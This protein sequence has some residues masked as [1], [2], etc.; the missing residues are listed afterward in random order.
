MAVGTERLSA[1][2][3][4]AAAAKGSGMLPLRGDDQHIQIDTHHL[5]DGRA[6]RRASA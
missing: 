4:A 5:Y 3:A 2:T 1:R 6:S